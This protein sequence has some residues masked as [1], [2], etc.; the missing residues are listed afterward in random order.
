MIR[1]TILKVMILKK[2]MRFQVQKTYKV[3]LV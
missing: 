2:L 3:Y 1:I